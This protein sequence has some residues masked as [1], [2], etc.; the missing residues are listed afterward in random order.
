[1][2]VSEA[3]SGEQDLRKGGT[4]YLPQDGKG[5]TRENLFSCSRCIEVRFED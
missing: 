2:V 4:A 1:M 3:T 5:F